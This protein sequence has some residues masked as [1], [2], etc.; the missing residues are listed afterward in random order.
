[1]MRPKW[2]PPFGRRGGGEG[3]WAPR[4]PPPLGSSVWP[5]R[6]TLPAAEDPP[7]E[8]SDSAAATDRRCLSDSAL[9]A[10]PRPLM[11]SRAVAL[12]VLLLLL[13]SVSKVCC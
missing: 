11:A 7:E 10:P 3:E 8:V 2:P 13:F 9:P 1:M 6:K 4:V 5:G 12:I